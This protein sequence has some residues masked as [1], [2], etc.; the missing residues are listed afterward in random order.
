MSNTDRQKQFEPHL[1]AGEELLWF[2]QYSNQRKIAG[3]AFAVSGAAF[4]GY[5]I[6]VLMQ[7]NKA[8]RTMPWEIILSVGIVLFVLLLILFLFFVA[9]SSREN[10]MIN[11]A[12]T[13]QRVLY[14]KQNALAAA[15]SIGSI[16]RLVRKNNNTLV[17]VLKENA[18]TLTFS[19]VND[20]VGL[21]ILLEGLI[22]KNNE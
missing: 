20:V 21:E 9:S 22:R 6:Y 12:I 13:N 19:K 10:G 3:W 1:Q 4:V 15:V 11:C 18:K 5:V 14:L 8:A 16:D 2:S 17:A 7:L